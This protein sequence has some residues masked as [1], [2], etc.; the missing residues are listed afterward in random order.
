M[1][2]LTFSHSLETPV[3][4]CLSSS[5]A[6]NSF[7]NILSCLMASVGV[8]II[9]SPVNLFLRSSVLSSCLVCVF[10]YSFLLIPY[11]IINRIGCQ[12]I[13]SKDLEPLR[14]WLLCSMPQGIQSQ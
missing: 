12:L 4:S 3:P 5:V 13:N 10:I 8:S 14:H 11:P 2:C 9:D 6:A 1:S 7:K